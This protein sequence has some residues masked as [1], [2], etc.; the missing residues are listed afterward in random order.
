MFTS[1]PVVQ[2]VVHD[3]SPPRQVQRVGYVVLGVPIAVASDDGEVLAL[4][5]DT[6]QG[7]R[8]SAGTL[9]PAF[10]AELIHLEPA[11]AAGSAAAVLVRDSDGYQREWPETPLGLIDL[12]DR[13]VH[14]VLSE[15]HK[16]DIYAVHA[17]ALVHQGA[18][19]IIAGRSGQ[20]KTTLTLGLLARGFGLLSDE[21]AVVEP[22]TQRIVPYRRSIHVRPG[23]PEL[24]PAL[25]ALSERPQQRLGGG[26]EWS[27]TPSELSQLFPG[28]LAAAAPLRYVLLL[29]GAPRPDQPPAITPLPAAVAT[30]EL[31]RGT[32]AAS[33]NFSAGLARLSQVMNS[34][35]CARLRV[36]A[37][38]ATLDVVQAWLEARNG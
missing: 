23:T 4:V 7:F 31:L 38:D 34:V 35:A 24:V 29:D 30:I 36:G 17:G 27:L 2:P 6:Y 15:L 28:C 1:L 33:R 16:R 22:A 18:A 37:F 8:N 32:W 11:G 21:F 25:H 9:E 20:G 3:E 13:I 14:G 19:L 5:D 26:I 10:S 12:F